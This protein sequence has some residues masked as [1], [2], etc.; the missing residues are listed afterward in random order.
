MVSSD[1][2]VQDTHRATLSQVRYKRSVGGKGKT[3]LFLDG[4]AV[5]DDHRIPVWL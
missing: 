2:L 3:L 4:Q 5:C 1:C